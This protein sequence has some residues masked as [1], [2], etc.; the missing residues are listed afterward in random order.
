MNTIRLASTTAV[1]AAIT[2][3]AV[4]ATLTLADAGGESGREYLVHVNFNETVTQADMDEVL[5]I[6]RQHDPDVDMAI[7]E[8]FP[9]QGSAIVK[10][11]DAGF[12]DAVVAEI[13]ARSYVRDATCNPHTPSGGDGDEPVSNEPDN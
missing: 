12:C 3:A 11:D 4:V 8:S 7:L 9:P 13:E 10:T 6:L 1:V 5:A 2:I